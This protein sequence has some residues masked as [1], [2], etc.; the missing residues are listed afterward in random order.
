MSIVYHPHR[1]KSFWFSYFGEMLQCLNR[2][3]TEWLIN[4]YI[5]RADSRFAPSQWEMPL[6]CNDVSHWLRAS[7]ES[8]LILVCININVNNTH[9]TDVKQ[10]YIWHKFIF[11]FLM[12][13][14]I[15]HG[16]SHACP[17]N[18]IFKEKKY[19]SNFFKSS[20]WILV[21]IY[22]TLWY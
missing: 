5:L 8:V 12:L 6:L 4:E 2:C 19:T 17:W 3:T 16:L 9:P 22:D 7:L 18:K 1:C 14:L 10:H 20:C 21:W 15:C 11:T 13:N